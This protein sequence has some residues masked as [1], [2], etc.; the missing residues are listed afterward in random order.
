MAI[1]DIRLDSEILNDVVLWDTKNWSN[2]IYFWLAHTQYDTLSDKKC[3]EIGARE[4][5]LSLLLAYLGC[6]KI[7]CSDLMNPREI[8]L[9]VHEKYPFAKA[10]ILYE[11]VDCLKI[12]YHDESFDIVTFKSV[13]GS[14]GLYENQIMSL[15]EIYRVLHYGGELWFAENLR[16][17]R[18]HQVFRK[19]FVRWAQRWYYPSVQEIIG[20][21]THSGFKEI[22]FRVYGFF[23]PFGYFEF[24][25]S[26]LATLDR[27]LD[28]HLPEEWKYIAFIVARK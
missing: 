23:A 10:R 8:A 20:G 2:A 16:A 7:V 3:L 5:C 6:E 15:K 28:K 18:L 1:N 9:K 13:L 12:P 17:S 22:E 4:G 24:F 21:L 14:L 26:A 19:A 25:R 27:V 11:S